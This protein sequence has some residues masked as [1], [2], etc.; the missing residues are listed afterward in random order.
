MSARNT[1]DVRLHTSIEAQLRLRSRE[2]GVFENDEGT[3]QN[4][5]ASRTCKC[6]CHESCLDVGW[7]SNLQLVV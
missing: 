1:I 3:Y 5:V 2:K 7:L 4:T 6:R